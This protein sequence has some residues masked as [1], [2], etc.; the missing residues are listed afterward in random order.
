MDDI[1]SIVSKYI[2]K[3][4]WKSFI[5]T[6]KLFFSFNKKEEIDKR[7]YH[8]CTLVFKHPKQAWDW[9]ILSSEDSTIPWYFVL[10]HLELSWDWKMLSH[11]KE[12]L[13]WDIVLNN[14]DKDW[15]WETLSYGDF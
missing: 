9:E 13:T 6:C 3:G 12:G 8:L 10:E 7:S 14:L 15:D 11:K 1:W 4:S 5:F 2:S